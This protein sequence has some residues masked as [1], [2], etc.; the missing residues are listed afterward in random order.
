MLSQNNNASGDLTAWVKPSGKDW[1]V[2]I[3]NP[4]NETRF[5]LGF[6]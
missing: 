1:M 5:F 6:Q 2:A 3:V 4:I